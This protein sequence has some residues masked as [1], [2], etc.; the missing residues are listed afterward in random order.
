M[1]SDGTGDVLVACL[2]RDEAAAVRSVQLQAPKAALDSVNTSL[3]CA[4]ALTQLHKG[5]LP[6]GASTALYWRFLATRRRWY[7]EAL[8]GALSW[9]QSG[10]E[11]QCVSP[12]PTTTVVHL[13]RHCRVHPGQ[14]TTTMREKVSYHVMLHP[15]FEGSLMVGGIAQHAPQHGHLPLTSFVTHRVRIESR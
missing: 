6:E 14:P 12:A 7:G 15:G 13:R 10:S 3:M 8:L 1:G 9:S 4:S 2:G 5:S 11:R